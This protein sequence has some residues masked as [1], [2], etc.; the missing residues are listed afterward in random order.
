[1]HALLAMLQ[2]GAGD[3]RIYPAVDDVEQRMQGTIGVPNGK[4]RVVRETWNKELSVIEANGT[5]DQLA[6]LYTSL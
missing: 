1:M 5:D 4:D 2:H 3:I 6:M